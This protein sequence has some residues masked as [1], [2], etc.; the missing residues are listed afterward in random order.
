[1]T[2]WI[3]WR[4]PFYTETTKDICKSSQFSDLTSCKIVTLVNVAIELQNAN[5]IGIWFMTAIMVYNWLPLWYTPEI[6]Y[7]AH[8]TFIR[9]FSH[10]QVET[11][12]TAMVSTWLSL[13]F[14]PGCHYNAHLAA[15]I[16]STQLPSCC[17]PDCHYDATCDDIRCILG[18][19]YGAY[20]YMVNICFDIMPYTCATCSLLH[21]LIPDLD[22]LVFLARIF[23]RWCY[24][25]SSP[26]AWW[27][28]LGP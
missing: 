18:C 5:Y 4:Q 3:C 26:W 24:T 10:T 8:R 19:H 27:L 20:L 16:I 2:S 12:M 22:V 13:W 23:M 1:M 15:K 11:I 14:P 28:S 25:T 9:L 17:K 7:C 6:H 21:V